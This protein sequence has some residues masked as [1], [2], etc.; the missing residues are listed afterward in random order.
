VEGLVE[1]ADGT[2]PMGILVVPQTLTNALAPNLTQVTQDLVGDGWKVSR[3]DAPR[4]DDTTWSNNPPNIAL[5]KS[6]VTND[7]NAD[8][9]N[10]YGSISYH[11]HHSYPGWQPFV[12]N[13]NA[14]TL[15]DC[16][17]YVDKLANIGTN[18]SPGKLIISASA[19][20]YGN[21][22]YVLDGIRFGGPTPYED[23][24]INGFVVAAAT[25]GLLAAGVPSSSIL[26]SDWLE[27]VSN[28]VLQTL[29]HPTGMTNVAGYVTWGVHSSLGPA[30]AT[31]GAVR[32][33]G[34]SG[35]WIIETVESFN[36]QRA[37]NSEQGNFIK[38]FSP[39]AFGGSNYSNTPIG[40][41]SH[42]EEPTVFG[43]SSSS[44][45]FG[46]W[47]G[48]KNFAIAAWNSRN[49]AFFQAAGDPLTTK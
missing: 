23:Y 18:Y 37:Q 36:G 10:P 49:T 11:L 44:P 5:I 26:F 40:A 27:V 1:A 8:P 21:T 41:V 43:V 32:W 38:W 24:S 9:D 39:T 20:G 17:A 35:W 30:Y 15:A 33:Y 29:P 19:G 14:G 12:N 3:H 2:E 25:N 7:Y 6:W 34:N 45:Y 42:V 13:L 28:N 31:S 46:L 16:E 47:A 4:H 48:A 22:N